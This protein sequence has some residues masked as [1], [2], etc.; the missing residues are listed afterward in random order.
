M[1][2][3]IGQSFTLGRGQYRI[4]DVRRLNG[5]SMVYAEE[6]AG[7]S[8]QSAS[9]QPGAAGLH[10]QRMAFHYSDIAGLLDAMDNK[11]A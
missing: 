7:S 4:V 9:G 6:L 8:A 10:P 2:Q 5:E 3:L 1:Q 11:I